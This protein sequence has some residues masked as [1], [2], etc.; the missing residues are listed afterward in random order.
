MSP[1]PN[2]PSLDRVVDPSSPLYCARCDASV[3]VIRVWSGW[4]WCWRVWLT[5]F[6]MMIAMTPLLAYDFCVIIPGMMVYIA[7]GGPLYHLARTRPVCRRCSLELDEGRT[8][9]TPLPGRTARAKGA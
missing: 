7:A 9:G 3:P 1:A 6:L 5:G 2:D 8:T 4:K